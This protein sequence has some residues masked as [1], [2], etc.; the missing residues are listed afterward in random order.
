MNFR[1]L[2][3]ASLLVALL[4][5]CASVDEDEAPAELTEFTAER[6]VS[7]LWSTSVGNGQ[8]QAW[9]RLQP[10]FDNNLVLAAANDGT[11]VALNATNGKRVWRKELDEE[12]IG[13]VGAGEG[14][15]LV[16][17]ADGSVLALDRN[18]GSEVWRHSV[19]GEVLAPPAVDGS[20]VIVQTY[21]GRVIALDAKT[22]EEQ[23]HY[24]ALLPRLTL[25]G[26]GTPLLA[27]PYVYVGFANGRVMA[28]AVDDGT[29]MWE[30][31]VSI[32]KG[33]TEIERLVDVDGRFILEGNVLYAVGY[34][35]RL[36][37]IDTATG[38]RFWDR[39]ASSHVGLAIGYN[40]VYVVGADGEI[41]AHK[42]NGQ[43]VTWTQTVLE[44]RQLA[45]PVTVA[46][47]LAVADFEGYIHFLSQVDGRLV[48][49]AKTGDGVR[50]PLVRQQDVVFSY[51][52]NGDLTAWRIGREDISAS[53]GGM[54]RRLFNRDGDEQDKPAQENDQPYQMNNPEWLEYL[55]RN[56]QEE[57][58]RRSGAN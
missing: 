57:A 33:S 10:V 5:A 58:Q 12:I 41:T 45:D 11:V 39:D 34:Q 18:N 50:A 35:G 27:G 2:S 6:A 52:N 56:D 43:G 31:R 55:L 49:R 4:S 42:H 32:P 46:G 37:A 23:W 21:N 19:A 24:Q 53:E 54:F 20:T 44:R 51:S 29:P 15:A 36:V 7:K 25:R 17:L 40:N 48:A 38:Q 28:L 16:G 9:N 14:L 30:V 1:L 26:T 13:G 3:L 22:G 47:M 8:G